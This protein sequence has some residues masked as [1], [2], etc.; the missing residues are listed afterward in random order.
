MLLV[1]IDCKVI[2]KEIDP[3]YTA[4]EAE[5]EMEKEELKMYQD[6]LSEKRGRIPQFDMQINR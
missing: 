1:E 5:T 4:K 3:D 6:R 2:W